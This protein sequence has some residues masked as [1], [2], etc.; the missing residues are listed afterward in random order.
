MNISSPIPDF[1]RDLPGALVLRVD[2]PGV[3][4]VALGDADAVVEAAVV[5]GLDL[6]DA[7][8]GAA[9]GLGLVQLAHH[10]T[11]L[12]GLDWNDRD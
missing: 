2:L 12:L 6:D 4:G 3:V 9:D 10:L 8:R 11:V 5:G 7:A 1:P